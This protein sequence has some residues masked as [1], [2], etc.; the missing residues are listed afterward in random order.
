M[1]WPTTAAV[2]HC[3]HATARQLDWVVHGL[4]VWLCPAPPPDLTATATTAAITTTTITTTAAITTTTAAAAAT[5]AAP[6]GTGDAMRLCLSHS[7]WACETAAAE[8]SAKRRTLRE[9]SA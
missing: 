5:T 1:L 9:V 7:R 2:Y 8:G 3:R 6:I 4:A